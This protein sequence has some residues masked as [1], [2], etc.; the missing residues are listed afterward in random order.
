M[1]PTHVLVL[2]AAVAIAAVAGTYAA[3]RTTQLSVASAQPPARVGT[4]KIASQNRALD[5]AQAALLAELKR[6][7]P[8]LPPVPAR[9]PVS[10][11]AVGP[12]AS[13]PTASAP[14]VY[15]RPKPVVHVIH[16]HGEGEHE[17]EGRNSASGASFDD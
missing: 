6:K 3:M 12:A 8:A 13:A 9:A 15:V 14:V 7:P 10:A 1:K 11:P 17:R 4:A 5:R 2:V 16:R